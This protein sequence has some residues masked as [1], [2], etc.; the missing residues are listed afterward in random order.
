VACE[1]AEK[2]FAELASGKPDLWRRLA[3]ELADRLR[4]RNALVIAPN[5]RPHLFIGSSTESLSVARAIQLG[6]EHDDVTVKVW[7][8]GVFGVSAF[9]IEA[10][11]DEI[12]SADFGVLVLSPDDKVLARGMV[13]EAPRDN[14]V[15][16][17]GICMGALTRTRTFF[18]YPRDIDIQRPPKNQVCLMIGIL[19][20]L[21]ADIS[22]MT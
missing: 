15:F 14:V 21:S 9:T 12:R 2:N 18:V 1:V 22:Q 6:L 4:Q 16:E 19:E 13:E 11:E 7:T 5:P 20:L 17:L 3:I 8:D 10:L